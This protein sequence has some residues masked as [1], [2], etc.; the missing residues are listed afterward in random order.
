[1]F[2]FTHLNHSSSPFLYLLLL[3]YLPMGLALVVLRI[4][5]LLVLLI[6]IVLTPNDF[7]FSP[8]MMKWLLP[9]FGFFVSSE[10]STENVGEIIACNHSTTFDVFP[11]MRYF[12]VNVVIDK[13]FFDASS[14]ARKFNKIVGAIPI[15]RGN[16]PKDKERDRRVIVEYLD[17]SERPLL[18]FPEG[19]DC[20][21]KVGLL[22]Y[23]KFL[24]SLGKTITP[25]AMTAHIPYLPLEPSVLGTSVVREVAWLFFY[26]YIIYHLKFLPSQKIRQNENELQFARRV[27]VVTAEALHIKATDYSFKEALAFRLSILESKKSK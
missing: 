27:Q 18:F 14:L 20:N 6:V 5:L 10:G 12:N 13:G 15:I 9:L 23:Q 7:T 25:V 11:F 17:K 26:P 22:V 19:W 16:N 3:L 8:S 24:F 4:T 21:G 1:M 2:T